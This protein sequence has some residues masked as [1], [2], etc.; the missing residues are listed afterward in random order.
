MLERGA[1]IRGKYRVERVL[2]RG[3]MG[4]V[5]RAHHLDLDQPVAIKLL[6]PGARDDDAMVQRFRREARAMVQLKG[7]H[8]AKVFDVG[9]LEN[10]APFMVMEYLEGQDLGDWLREQKRLEPGFAVD[11]VL[12]ACEA[13]A[14]A[15]AAGIV[16]RDIKP[17]NFFLTRGPDGTPL[18]KVLDFGIAKAPHAVNEDFTSSQALMGTPT[19]MSPEQMHSSKKVDPRTD[20]WAL[21]VVLYE[22]VSGR[23]PFRADSYAGLCLA[24]TTAPMRPLHD[25]D[26]ADGLEAIIVRCLQ[27]QPCRRFGDVAELAAALVPY[28]GNAAQASRSSE[29]AACILAFASAPIYAGTTRLANAPTVSS[30]RAAEKAASGPPSTIDVRSRVSR[31]SPGATTFGIASTGDVRALSDSEAD[32]SARP[33]RHSQWYLLMAS[34]SL[35]V[36]LVL[37]LLVVLGQ[38]RPEP[39]DQLVIDEVMAPA[40]D[41]VHAAAASAPSPAVAV[42]AGAVAVP[43]PPPP[44]A[45]V[46]EA[47]PATPPEQ[48]SAQPATPPARTRAPTK[49]AREKLDRPSR[50]EPATRDAGAAESAQPDAPA[51]ADPYGDYD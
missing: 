3:A 41:V 26:M 11:L 47:E 30:K 13:L 4:I 19:Y 14:E 48:P 50:A 40:T 17:A 39:V 38:T 33:A 16:H 28:A 18:L 23:R 24:V 27:K 15:H 1:V 8:V 43:S 21:G 42:D 51:D 34:I 5:A 37:V 9:T 10:G 44:D 2:G 45:G 6:L 46:V 36:A 31:P 29:R 22:L 25:I 20:I 12:Q 49:R 7:E 32:P 35:G